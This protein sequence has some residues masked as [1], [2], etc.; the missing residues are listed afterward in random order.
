MKRAQDQIASLSDH[1]ALPRDLWLFI[2]TQCE[3]TPALL[4]VS[5]DWTTMLD[6]CAHTEVQNWAVNLHSHLK[7]LTRQIETCVTENDLIQLVYRSNDP[8]VT[9]CCVWRELWPG[10]PVPTQLWLANR[11]VETYATTLGHSEARVKHLYRAQVYPHCSV[12]QHSSQFRELLARQSG[13]RVVMTTKLDYITCTDGRQFTIH[14][15]YDLT[16]TC[17]TTRPCLLAYPGTEKPHACE[18]VYFISEWSLEEVCERISTIYND[19]LC[20]T[21]AMK[22]QFL[23]FPMKT[24]LVRLKRL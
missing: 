8:F 13:K 20:A 14:N 10:A 4:C 15:T 19:R 22:L 3:M 5:H 7:F 18:L 23:K 21:D 24:A 2:L 6:Q 9:A 1:C 11:R 12:V 16:N 17:V